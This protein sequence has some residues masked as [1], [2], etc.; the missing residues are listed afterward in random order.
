[1]VLPVSP[2]TGE[3]SE[4]DLMSVAAGGVG[5]NVNN[6]VNVNEGANVNVGGNINAGVNA[7]A[8]VDIAVIAVVAT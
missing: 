7:N 8:G 3:M 4:E 5:A 2:P 1:M 6:A